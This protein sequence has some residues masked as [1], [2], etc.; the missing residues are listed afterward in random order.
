MVTD[1]A[2][3]MLLKELE[4][5]ECQSHADAS[6][7]IERAKAEAEAIRIR[8]EAEA[9]A[10]RTKAAA[11]Q[12]PWGKSYSRMEW[13]QWWG[14]TNPRAP[15]TASAEDDGDAAKQVP[16]TPYDNSTFTRWDHWSHKNHNHCDDVSWGKWEDWS[17]WSRS[18]KE[19]SAYWSMQKLAGAE[20]TR[21]RSTPPSKKSLPPA[22]DWHA[23]SSSGDTYG[24]V[25]TTG[26]IRSCDK[27]K[28]YS[29]YGSTYEKKD[30]D[31]S[32][33]D[34]GKSYEANVVVRR[35]SE[36]PPSKASGTVQRNPEWSTRNL[37]GSA[38]RNPN[39]Q[40]RDGTR[41]NTPKRCRSRDSPAEQGTDFTTE[42]DAKYELG[43]KLAAGS[44]GVAFL[45]TEKSNGMTVVAKRPNNPK[46]TR[47]YDRLV[48]KRHPNIVRVFECFSGPTETFVVMEYY[49]GGDLFKAVEGHGV[50]LGQT[51]IA[52]VFRQMLSGVKY[53]HDFGESHNDLKLE[54][55]LLDHKFTTPDDAPRIVIAD[56]GSA[57]AAG[58]RFGGDPRYRA[59]ET[60]FHAPFGFESDVWALGV[61]LYE[62]ISGG[63]L[64]HVQQQNIC[65]WREFESHDGGALCD[66]FMKIMRSRPPIPVP[67][68]NITGLEVQDL[69]GDLLDLYPYRRMTME[70]ALAHPW[71][72]LACANRADTTCPHK[73]T[74]KA[75][76][77]CSD[78]EEDEGSERP[79]SPRKF[80][81]C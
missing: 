3:E 69:L 27:W 72:A 81:G 79:R 56:L 18:R 63:L 9:D 8:A 1:P 52:K 33:C 11:A 5:T 70:S 73:R 44:K 25:S 80:G 19:I 39:W 67:L 4:N 16:G 21:Q 62:L 61:C 48:D 6:A 78:A 20:K 14:Q 64:I 58:S 22:A 50:N 30:D 29:G 46:D 60:F 10:I 40:C 45:A 28:S 37:R 54:N 55:I 68:D 34:Y 23:N 13:T 47:D 32:W 71:L 77:A 53:L 75:Q 66:R 24:V 76:K 7:I 38:D 2:E 31:I 17:S 41:W 15:Q 26:S 57:G 74:C 35:R 59:P 42:F 65:G 12:L 36:P 49:A 43:Q 51:W